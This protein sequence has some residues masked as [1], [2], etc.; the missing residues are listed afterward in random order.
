MRGFCLI[1][2]K[3]VQRGLQERASY[4]TMKN[5]LTGGRCFA[6]IACLIIFVKKELYMRTE[7]IYEKDGMCMSFRAEIIET[8]ETKNGYA[9]VLDRTAFF[10]EGGGQTADTGVIGG[11]RVLD[12]QIR[13]GEILHYVPTLPEGRE[14]VCALDAD[15]RFR[16][17]QNHLGEHLLCGAIHRA[18]GF[19]NVGFHLGA[20]YMTFDIS[21]PMTAEEIYAAE[22]E[23][24]K[25]IAADAP[26]RCYV[27][28]KEELRALAYR[29]KSEKLEN[30]EEIRIVDVEG[31]DRCACCAPHLDRAGKL[32][33][34]KIV[35]AMHYKG[36]MRFWALCGFDALKD[37]DT[38]LSEIRALSVLFSAKPHEVVSAAS[39]KMD[40]ISQLKASIGNMRR[41]IVKLKLAL[42]PSQNGSVIVFED[43]MDAI[44]MREFATAGAEKTAGIFAVF[45]GNDET[46]Y[47]FT[48]TAKNAPLK[49]LAG[50]IRK[51]LGG[52]CG[53]SDLMITGQVSCTKAEA[54]AFLRAKFA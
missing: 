33:L 10:P 40:E 46:G 1:V 15:E 7:K 52:K 28:E 16:K 47:R 6:R 9:L 22:V 17:M 54:E 51:T 53:G 24:N 49:A 25:A 26:V 34:I 11:V 43:D 2:I 35:D 42:I 12:V 44:S 19:E 13:D 4:G 18:H 3:S 36:G 20:D 27:P 50:E 32:G 41:E 37:Y 45:S 31:F 23:A 48:A 5:A 21:G 39:A 38:R 29:A 14:V 8:R 30:A